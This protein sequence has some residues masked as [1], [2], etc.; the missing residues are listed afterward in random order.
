MSSPE[1]TMPQPQHSDSEYFD[2]DD[3]P[4]E[5]INK[6]FDQEQSGQQDNNV[7]EYNPQLLIPPVNPPIGSSASILPGF[8]TMEA[9]ASTSNQ[10]VRS[11]SLPPE[12]WEIPGLV[13]QNGPWF[14]TTTHPSRLPFRPPSCPPAHRSLAP[15]HMSRA[16]SP[17]SVGALYH[18]P[19][20]ASS[21]ASSRAPSRASSRQLSP[22]PLDHSFAQA[23]SQNAPLYV[24]PLNRPFAQ[25]TSQN[26]PHYDPG[27]YAPAF[28]PSQAQFGVP[29]PDNAPFTTSHRT[30]TLPAIEEEP[31]LPHNE[32]SAP[33]GRRPLRQMD[34]VDVADTQI[35]DILQRL[36]DTTGK[37]V[38]TLLAQLPSLQKQAP[39]VEHSWNTYQSFMV[40][41][42]SLMAEVHR[43]SSDVLR[44]SFPYIADLFEEGP[45]AGEE[46]DDQAEQLQN[47]IIENNDFSRIASLT[48]P[49]FQQ[50]TGDWK[51][52][53][54]T[55]NRYS[56]MEKTDTLSQRSRVFHTYIRQ[57][58]DMANRASL[59]HRFDTVI[60]CQGSQVLNDQGLTFTH[61]TNA[62]EGFTLHRLGV[63][64]LRLS[65]ALPDEEVVEQLKAGAASYLEK[66]PA[67][68]PTPEGYGVMQLCKFVRAWMQA[69]AAR[70]SIDITQNSSGGGPGESILFSGLPQRLASKGVR[71]IYWRG[72]FPNEIELKS[73]KTK[74]G[75]AHQGYQR[76]TL[77]ILYELCLGILSKEYPMHMDFPS[78][79]ELRKKIQLG[80]TWCFGQAPPQP[81]S[82]V[83]WASTL[84]VISDESDPKAVIFKIE[85]NGPPRLAVST[86]ID[87]PVTAKGRKTVE[88]EKERVARLV[89]TPTGKA[90]AK[91]KEKAGADDVEVAT[92][93][94]TR[95]TGKG[96]ATA[97]S[98]KTKQPTA[99]KNKSVKIVEVKSESSEDELVFINIAGGVADSDGSEYEPHGGEVNNKGESRGDDNVLP[100][101][102]RPR[103]D[104]VEAPKK[105]RRTT[106]SASAAAAPPSTPPASSRGPAHPPRQAVEVIIH[107]PTPEKAAE[108]N[109]LY[110]LMKKKKAQHNA[111]ANTMAP[112][113][114][115]PATT[116]S[117]KGAEQGVRVGPPKKPRVVMTR[118]S[119]T[120]TPIPSSSF[121][122]AVGSSFSPTPFS[123][124][125]TSSTMQTTPHQFGGGLANPFG[126]Q[127]G[128]KGIAGGAPV[129]PSFSH[130][131]GS[132]AGLPPSTSAAAP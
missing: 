14:P 46:L 50:N 128:A 112:P 93:K 131:V 57:M 89:A 29:S 97:S 71:M 117:T 111:S 69:E 130:P 51:E 124:V 28:P 32:A 47:L 63:D 98:T 39:L 45:V 106:R 3:I 125:A 90:Q 22:L 11:P 35:A 67:G 16:Q 105:S 6:F 126:P 77:P 121:S 24:P 15:S 110:G 118:D 2:S 92:G 99:K 65:S 96:T 120:P 114:H 4:D 19:S 1:H 109:R 84:R 119:S 115:P 10:P 30:E 59:Y 102:K 41:P 34:L 78:D 54:S 76:L 55:F 52:V 66:L 7:S 64:K 20:R 94:A 127:L 75:T 33:V 80:K 83:S 132:S 26:M 116:T 85:E 61:E 58:K 9:A 86:D 72:L 100:H 123:D 129:F 87:L 23:A 53:L 18:A 95:K 37:S 48:F 31:R 12:Q 62:L 42:S 56:Q 91:G 68:Y 27:V 5:A 122:P 104:I 13:H 17:A 8:A 43:L 108:Q 21:R 70:L 40:A 74:S 60:F 49:L 44:E 107:A 25:T 101:T 81:D 113:P 103:E 36:S 38:S 82:P 88:R 79:L 73:S